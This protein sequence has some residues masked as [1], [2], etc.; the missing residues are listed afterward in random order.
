MKQLKRSL[1]LVLALVML[2]SLIY[3][4][5]KAE[6]ANAS[7]Y[8]STSYAANLSVK[9]TA[10][11]GLR[12][13]PTTSSSA[14]YTLPTNTMLAVKALHKGTDSRWWYEVLFYDMTLYV[15]ATATT[16]VSH[17]TG[18]VS[19][20]SVMSPASL[21]KGQSFGIEGDTPLYR[22]GILLGRIVYK[23]DAIDDYDEDVR[24]DRYNP[25]RAMYGDGGFTE[26]SRQNAASAIR[27]DLC[28][29]EKVILSLPFGEN[30]EIEA[31][32]KNILYLGLDARLDRKGIH[33]D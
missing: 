5:P 24:R 30:E 28:E 13:L 6:A 12:E 7:S 11:T 27:Y 25:Y 22:L 16:K 29:L 17:L 2:M 1:S 4:A 15:D 33:N 8:I 9:T 21:Y 10:A 26:E 32:M 31:L 14:K 19:I 18:D 20:D 3:V 23:L